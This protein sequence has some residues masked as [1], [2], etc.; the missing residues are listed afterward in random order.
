VKSLL[1][2]SRPARHSHTAAPGQRASIRSDAVQPGHQL[3]G[4]DVT[5][6]ITVRGPRLETQVLKL[7]R[8][9]GSRSAGSKAGRQLTPSGRKSDSFCC[10]FRPPPS[11]SP[12]HMRTAIAL[13]L[14][15]TG[16]RIVAALGIR[17][18]SIFPAHGLSLL[19]RRLLPSSL[20]VLVP[21][22]GLSAFDLISTTT[23]P[24]VWHSWDP[25]AAH[26]AQRCALWAALRPG[27]DGGRTRAG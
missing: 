1:G 22:C 19:R 23:T 10:P 26:R 4:L 16:Y 17:E 7:H 9:A 15:A 2:N 13:I 6:T 18:R 27:L 3:R 11:Q 14:L 25:L 5:L 8:T 12:S 24:P 20:D 21:F